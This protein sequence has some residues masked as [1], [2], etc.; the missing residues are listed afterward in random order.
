[1]KRTHEGLTD[2]ILNTL[3]FAGMNFTA[4]HI[5]HCLKL[6]PRFSRVTLA[7]VSG[8]LARLV[9]TERAIAYHGCGIRD[10]NGY[11]WKMPRPVCDDLPGTF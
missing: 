8:I 1:M 5:W 2:Q 10:G 9:R 11:A 3:R 7:T 6:N 4:T